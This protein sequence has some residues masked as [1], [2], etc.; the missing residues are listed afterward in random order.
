M[1][2]GQ[3]KLLVQKKYGLEPAEHQLSFRSSKKV[4]AS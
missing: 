3:L 2:V 1:K 4:L